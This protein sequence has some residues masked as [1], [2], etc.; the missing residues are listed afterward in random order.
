MSL[1]VKTILLKNIL[2]N[3][4]KNTLKPHALNRAKTPAEK[5]WVQCKQKYDDN[6]LHSFTD[7]NIICKSSIEN[8]NPEN[9]FF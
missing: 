9:V 5:A 4:L 7:L 8:K 3:A 6:Q 2:K 1:H